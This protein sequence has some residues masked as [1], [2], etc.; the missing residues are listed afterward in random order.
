M[1]KLVKGIEVI[2][3]RADID[4]LWQEVDGE[5]KANHSCGHD[6]NISMVLGALLRIKDY[7]FKEANAV[8]FPTC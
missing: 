3:V 1:L 4:A 7:S 6:A 5:M 2:A 8:Y